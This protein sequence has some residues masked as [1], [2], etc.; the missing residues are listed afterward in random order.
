MDGYY[1]VMSKSY[2]RGPVHLADL[3]Y[4]E[5]TGRHW[6]LYQELEAHEELWDAQHDGEVEDAYIKEAIF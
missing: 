5:Y 2:P 1:V 6:P 3:D 4:E